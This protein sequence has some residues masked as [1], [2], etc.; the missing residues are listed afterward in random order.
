MISLP[1]IEEALKPYLQKNIKFTCDDKTVKQGKL[2]FYCSKDFFCAFTLI[3]DTKAIKKIVYEIPYPFNF[4]Q[5]ANSVTFNYSI[6]SFCNSSIDLH[7]I[8]GTLKIKKTS[9]LFN[10]HLVISAS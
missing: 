9:K 6:S 7:T 5:N 8:V 1:Q 2:L 10:R 4:H 3:D